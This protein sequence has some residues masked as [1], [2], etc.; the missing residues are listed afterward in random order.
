L[1]TGEKPFWIPSIFYYM[2]PPEVR[3]H[4]VVNVTPYMTQWLELARYYG[5]QIDN[6]PGYRMRLEAHKRLAGSL[7][8]AEFGEAFTC[9]RPLLGN[10]L[11]L[12]S[13]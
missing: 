1:E 6:I 7:I 9:D 12:T 5:S 4:F 13:I 11:D 10:E 2:F 8:D 3:P